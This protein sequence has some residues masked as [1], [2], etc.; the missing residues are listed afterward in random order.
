MENPFPTGLVRIGKQQI[1]N[2]PTVG[3]RDCLRKIATAP[4]L[5]TDAQTTAESTFRRIER[6]CF[7]IATDRPHM[8][9]GYHV[10][11][12]AADTMRVRMIELLQAA[13][14]PPNEREYPTPLD[15][16]DEPEH[17]TTARSRLF[18]VIEVDHVHGID[19]TAGIVGGHEPKD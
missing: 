16:D 18:D 3:I 11:R 12:V 6:S 4:E 9:M 10:H 7:G 5:V 19:T 15:A 2:C 13:H 14:K 17:D 8:N 1:D